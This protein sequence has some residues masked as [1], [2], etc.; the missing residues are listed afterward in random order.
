M[1]DRE[2]WLL[3][4]QGLKMLQDDPNLAD[5]SVRGIGTITKA[6]DKMLRLNGQGIVVVRDETGA[7]LYISNKE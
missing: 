7:I 4:K 3:V 5:K 2:F 6:I 1:E